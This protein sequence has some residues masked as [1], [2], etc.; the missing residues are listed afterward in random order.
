MSLRLDLE[1]ILETQGLTPDSVR[2]M[3]ELSRCEFAQSPLLSAYFARS[4]FRDMTDFWDDG[5]AIPSDEYDEVQVE[6]VPRL[7]EWLS[8]D[9]SFH[10]A[11][12]I[13]AIVG[14]IHRVIA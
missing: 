6:I 7:Q 1:Q 11:E 13:E 14:E 2:K 10:D 9:Q 12:K 5:Q 3:S 4:L 8:S